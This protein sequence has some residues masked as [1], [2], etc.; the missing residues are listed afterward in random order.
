MQAAAFFFLFTASSH[1]AY[2]GRVDVCEL[3]HVVGERGDVRI[4]QIILWRWYDK[5]SGPSRFHVAQWMIPLGK[6]AT[7]SKRGNRWAVAWRGP[8]GMSYEADATTWLET[9]TT[10]DPERRD[11]RAWPESA[12]KPY[13]SQRK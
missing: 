9:W 4:T 6:E 12:R 2:R 13:F 7:A 11:L 1:N 3:N 10:R 8:D 5:H